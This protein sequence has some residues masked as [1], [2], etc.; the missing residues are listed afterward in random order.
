M[1][2]R[3]QHRA[4][5]FSC[6][7]RATLALSAYA[8]VG[9]VGTP[10]PEPP[11]FLSQPDRS[12]ISQ[13]TF[14]V[15]A[16]QVEPLKIIGEPGAVTG[17]TDV[18]LVNLDRT[19]GAVIVR[20]RDDGSFTAAIEASAGD[21]IR[22]V[23]RTETRHSRPLDL[24]VTSMNS[25]LV[26][27]PLGDTALSCLRIEPNDELKLVTGETR[28]YRVTNEC[29]GSVTLANAALRFGNQGFQLSPP[30]TMLTAGE[31]VELTVSFAG[32]NPREQA[33]ILLVDVAFGAE[34]GR[35]ALGLWGTPAD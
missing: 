8:L 23:S 27:E 11:D 1:A 9:C 7:L 26:V 12:K 35:Y 21:R 32:E 28:A 15:G 20:A 5:P 10:T 2:E 18:W 4:S 3:E 34:G 29:A 24:L 25:A 19:N 16:N 33:D 31:Q 17:D 14:E 30:P 13:P 6:A 22:L